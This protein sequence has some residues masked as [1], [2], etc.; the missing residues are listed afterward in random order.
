[1]HIYRPQMK[2]RECNVFTPV[3]QSFSSQGEGGC[4]DVTSCYK[5][6]L[7]DGT[8]THSQQAGILLECFLVRY[9]VTFEKGVQHVLSS[10]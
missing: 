5:P 6:H 9:K 8:P 4:H 1:M 2:L 3:C 7:Q 10:L